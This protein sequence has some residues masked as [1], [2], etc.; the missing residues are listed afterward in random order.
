LF[1]STV[2]TNSASG[3]LLDGE[4]VVGGVCFGHAAIVHGDRIRRRWTQYAGDALRV[5]RDDYALLR[6][7]L[8]NGH[9]HWNFGACIAQVLDRDGHGLLGEIFVTNIAA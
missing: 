4:Y 5:T 3:R 1:Y 2:V 6:F 8:G 7:A 9:K